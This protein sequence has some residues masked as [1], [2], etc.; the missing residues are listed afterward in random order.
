MAPLYAI[1]ERK[2]PTYYDSPVDLLA[3]PAL[4]KEEMIIN[5]LLKSNTRVVIIEK[6]NQINFYNKYDFNNTNPILSSLI[7]QHFK[8]AQVISNY[9]IYVSKK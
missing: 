3:R 7:K 6:G 4:E 5:S 1:T 9:E 2:N 8:L